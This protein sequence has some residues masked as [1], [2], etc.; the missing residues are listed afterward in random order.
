MGKSD[1]VLMIIPGLMNG[2]M[3]RNNYGELVAGSTSI[4]GIQ[5]GDLVLIFQSV[6]G[7]RSNGQAGGVGLPIVPSGYTR[8]ATASS[9]GFDLSSPV[10]RYISGQICFSIATQAQIGQS[11]QGLRTVLSMRHSDGRN[12]ERLSLANRNAPYSGLKKAPLGFFQGQIRSVGGLSDPDA[13]SLATID[14]QDF[15]N[16]VLQTENNSGRRIR[17]R[18]ALALGNRMREENL[19][20][21][22][23]TGLF[24]ADGGVWA[25][26]AK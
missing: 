10:W 25:V 19:I 8:I 6:S 16:S 21:Y 14:G 20:T 3:G 11:I 2:L 7:S 17:M 22:D 4:N 18:M 23:S 24:G 9:S 12:L 1:G 5:V 26:T 15:S 13:P